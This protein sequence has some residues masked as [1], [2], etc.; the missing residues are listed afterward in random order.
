MKMKLNEYCKIHNLKNNK[1]LTEH[2]KYNL[3]HNFTP[4]ALYSCPIC[5][6]IIWNPAT[7]SHICDYKLEDK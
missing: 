5:Y 6:E 4:V 2:F 1:D 3:A 7:E